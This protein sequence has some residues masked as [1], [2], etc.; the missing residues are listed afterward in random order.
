MPSSESTLCWIAGTSKEFGLYRVSDDNN[1]LVAK[2]EAHPVDDARRRITQQRPG[3][4]VVLLLQENGILQR[5]R[6]GRQRSHLQLAPLQLQEDHRQHN[7]YFKLSFKDTGTEFEPHFSFV[8]LNYF[9]ANQ[10]EEPWLLVAWLCTLKYEYWIEVNYD[11][12]RTPLH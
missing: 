9:R 5:Q 1:V 4:H 6:T 8:M 11:W 2:V 10:Y 12:R 7:I 3:E